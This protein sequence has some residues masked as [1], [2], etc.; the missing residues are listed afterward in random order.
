VKSHIQAERP[1]TIIVCDIIATQKV[2][3]VA[4]SIVLE[5]IIILIP[6]EMLTRNTFLFLTWVFEKNKITSL[7]QL[8]E[9]A[10]FKI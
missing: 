7:T 5:N 4:L 9:L 3:I 1:F 8:R 10:E 6:K 2:L